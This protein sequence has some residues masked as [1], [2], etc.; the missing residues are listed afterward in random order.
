M[1]AVVSASSKSE[2]AYAW[3][4]R[5]IQE[6]AFTPGY[7]LVLGSIADE[8]GMSVVPVREALRRLE[9]EGYVTFERNVGA[10]VTAIDD[11]EYL[12]TMQTLGVVEGIA[13][14]LAMPHITAEV[15]DEA[16]ALNARM[17]TLTADFDA[18]AFTQLNRAFHALLFEHCPNPHLLDLVG[19]GWTRMTGFRDPTFSVVPERAES[20]VRE[21][22]RL[23]AL[24]R[25]GAD[26]GVVEMAARDHRWRTMDAYLHTHRNISTGASS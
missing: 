19:R 23:L 14:A 3:I 9:A 8:L 24:L 22:D 6:Q 26:P 21:H 10:R 5:R 2:H 20:S 12:Y 18:P 25:E 1:T 7:R 16:A 13:T 4:H 17:H 11:R 15:L